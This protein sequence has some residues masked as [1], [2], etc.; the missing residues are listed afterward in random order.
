MK[1]LSISNLIIVN[2]RQ[3]YFSLIFYSCKDKVVDSNKEVL[4]YVQF[5]GGQG[6]VTLLLLVFVFI[7]LVSVFLTHPRF[8]LLGH[9]RGCLL[10]SLV[11]ALLGG[12][13]ALRGLLVVEL[14]RARCAVPGVRGVHDVALLVRIVH[15]HIGVVL[16]FVRRHHTSAVDHPAS[17]DVV[18]LSVLGEQKS[19]VFI[20]VCCR[21]WSVLFNH[22]C[23]AQRGSSWQLTSFTIRPLRLARVYNYT[24][25]F[26]A[27]LTY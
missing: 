1:E 8:P 22:V 18:P 3:K 10:A 19:G 11:G 9:L 13:V 21:W 16:R 24:Y 17:T 5:P 14:L 6:L 2:V 15:H 7:H 23:G 25:M 27:T 20:F 12:V 4:T 26:W